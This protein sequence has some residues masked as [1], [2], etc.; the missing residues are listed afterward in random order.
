[1]QKPEAFAWNANVIFDVLVLLNRRTGVEEVRRGFFP[2]APPRRTS[3]TPRRLLGKKNRRPPPSTARA[4]LSEQNWTI[5]LSAVAFGFIR[6]VCPR[7]AIIHR[8]SGTGNG[9]AHSDAPKRMISLVVRVL[10]LGSASAERSGDLHLPR[11]FIVLDIL[12]ARRHTP[13]HVAIY[14]RLGSGFYR[15]THRSSLQPWR[16]AA[17]PFG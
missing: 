14:Y 11:Y 7:S 5:Y 4:N 10:P 13:G 15:R 3:A 16:G 8:D 9:P 6:E 12:G 2:P 1:M 17:S